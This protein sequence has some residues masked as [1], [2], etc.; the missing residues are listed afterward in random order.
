MKAEKAGYEH[1]QK[2]IQHKTEQLKGEIEQAKQVLKDKE[3]YQKEQMLK[4]NKN[5]ER[6]QVNK[7]RV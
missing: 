1:E 6:A 4:M 2:L 3:V 7:K 5:V